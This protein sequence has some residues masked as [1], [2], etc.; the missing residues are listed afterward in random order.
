VDRHPADAR[1]ALLALYTENSAQ[2][3]HYEEQ[4]QAI[5]TA[6]AVVAAL[7]LGFL[8]GHP[9]ETPPGRGVLRLAAFLLVTTAGFGFGASLRSYERSRLHVA[10]VH[11]VRKEL[12]AAFGI[13][14]QRLYRAADEE[15]A[16]RFPRLPQHTGRIHYLW[17]GFHLAVMLLGGAL[18]LLA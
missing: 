16:R 9:G 10:R 15:H 4:R 2:A 11:A 18:A 14:I 17:Q 13:D 5:T 7:V 8:V 6:V 12:S 3:R 1:D